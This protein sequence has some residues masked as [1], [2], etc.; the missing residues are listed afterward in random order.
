MSQPKILLGPLEVTRLLH[1]RLNVVSFCVHSLSMRLSIIENCGFFS[2]PEFFVG[3]F[4]S[5]RILELII[6]QD[7]KKKLEKIIMV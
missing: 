2:Q 5:Q 4:W 7:F 1:S 3:C 6:I